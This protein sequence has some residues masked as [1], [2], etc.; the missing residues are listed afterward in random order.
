V[1]APLSCCAVPSF[2]VGYAVL[3]TI[4]KTWFIRRWG[5]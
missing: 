5:M 2:L 3:T 4:V 1:R